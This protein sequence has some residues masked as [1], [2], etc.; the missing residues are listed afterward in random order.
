LL[1]KL[2]IDGDFAPSIFDWREVL[3]TIVHNCLEQAFEPG[4]SRWQVGWSQDQYRDQ[5]GERPVDNT[6][7]RTRGRVD[8]LQGRPKTFEKR[9]DSLS[10]EHTIRLGDGRDFRNRLLEPLTG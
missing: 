6:P 3:H 8:V 7:E 10:R 5:F 2:R 1:H 4:A 9:D